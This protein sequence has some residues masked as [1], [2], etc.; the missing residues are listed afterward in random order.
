MQSLSLTGET[1]FSFQFFSQAEKT[2]Y[3]FLLRNQSHLC[4]EAMISKTSSEAIY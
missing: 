2:Q 3:I 4:P 1:Y